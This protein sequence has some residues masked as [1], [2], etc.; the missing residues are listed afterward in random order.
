MKAMEVEVDQFDHIV[1]PSSASTDTFP[2]QG[3]KKNGQKPA[4]KALAKPAA[5]RQGRKGGKNDIWCAGCGAFVKADMFAV[6]QDKCCT[7]KRLLDRI[8]K[9]VERQGEQEWLAKQKRCPKRLKAMLDHMRDNKT[10][11][12]PS[13][14]VKFVA[15][16][17]REF[18]R[19]EQAQD[20]TGRGRLMWEQQ[21]LGLVAHSF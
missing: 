1:A 9:Q 8:S 13:R 5:K 19:T 3:G 17:L 11:G 14:P 21:V 2:E 18:Q 10:G 20:V 12:N 7:C 6:N 15:A 4:E 16:E